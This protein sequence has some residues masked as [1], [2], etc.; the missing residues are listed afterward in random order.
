LPKE[1]FIYGTGKLLGAL[2]AYLKILRDAFRSIY[3]HKLRSIL[4]ILGIVCG[5]MAVLAMISIGEGAKREVLEG[6]RKLGTHLIY[7]RSATPASN[8]ENPAISGKA[9]G[10][11]H[12]DRDRIKAGCPDITAVAGF[13]EFSADVFSAYNPVAATV[14]ASSA[15]LADILGLPIHQGRFLKQTDLDAGAK[16]CV[17]GKEI[18]DQVLGREDFDKRLRIGG[19]LFTVV[20]ILGETTWRPDNSAVIATRNYN[21]MVFIPLGLERLFRTAQTTF[22]GPDA[23]G[24]TEL[25]VKIGDHGDISAS[26]AIIERILEASHNGASDY[27][28]IVPRQLLI[29]AQKAQRTFNWMLAAVAGISLLVGGIGVMN[30]MLASVSERTREIGIRRAVGATR[31]DIVVQFLF[32]SVIMT[33]MGG[34]IGVILGGSVVYLVSFAASWQLA[35]NARALAVPLGLAIGVGLFFGIFPAV[36]AARMEPINAL[37]QYT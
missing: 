30:I 19:H 3:L 21:Q 37:R 14:M 29:E 26:A 4:S 6:I 2:D 10:L 35:I 8:N 12:Y 24:L 11:T 16:V 33:F 34:I 20:G 1:P 28:M 7:I 27:E 31:P 13:Q 5:V 17:M 9:L 22:N 32:E 23:S 25:I 15:D 18:A 36:K